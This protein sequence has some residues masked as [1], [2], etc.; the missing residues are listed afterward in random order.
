VLG[1]EYRG[2]GQKASDETTAPVL[3]RG[4]CGRCGA[5]RVD[6]QLGTEPTVQEYVTKLVAVFRELRRVLR[7]DGTFWLVI[8]D[9]YG[10]DGN[11]VGA[12]WRLAFALQD[13]GWVL[14]MDNIWRKPDTMPE[15][16]NNR[17]TKA[18]EYVF[19]FSK[20]PRYYYDAEAVKE[21]SVCGYRDWKSSP[22]SAKGRPGSHSHY[23]GG[24]TTRG[25]GGSTT[26]G[27]GSPRNKRSVW[28]ISHGGGYKGGHFACVDSET[29]ALTRTGWKKHADILQGECIA[30]YNKYRDV[31]VWQPATIHRYEFSGNLVV[32]DKRDTSQHL[33]PNHRC[34]VQSR[35]G[36]VRVKRAAAVSGKDR[37]LMTA[38]FEEQPECTIGRDMAAL[39]GWYTSEGCRHTGRW[40]VQ[41]SQSK[42]ANPEKVEEIRSL[43]YRM[44]A[45]FK[46]VDRS[47]HNNAKERHEMVFHV[48][49]R[50]ANRLL[51]LCPNKQVTD[52]LTRLPKDELTVLLETFISGDGHRRK[53]DYRKCIT[54][55][56]RAHLER[57]QV[58]A[59]KLGYRAH[60]SKRKQDDCHVLYLTKG[61]WLEARGTNG[62]WFGMQTERYDGCVWC[63]NVESGFWLARREG[64][65]FITGNTF[66]KALVEVCVK[67]G[68]SEKGCCPKCG[69]PWARVLGQTRTATR[70]GH[71]TKTHGG[72]AVNGKDAAPRLAGGVT[73]NRDPARHVTTTRTLGWRPSCACYGLPLV[74][75]EPREPKRSPK[76]R[77]DAWVARYSKYQTA[78]ASWEKMWDEVR[79]EYAALLDTVDEG[80]L[81]PCVVLDP[82]MGSGTAALVAL[83]LGRH[84]VGIDVSEAYLRD[85]A[86]ARVRGFLLSRPAYRGLVPME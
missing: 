69:A 74:S 20:G 17:S 80:S 53:N 9:C 28:T 49:G 22:D 24:D 38:E 30:A 60:L 76:E 55:K 31:L 42:L 70:P 35:K 11:L 58:I 79:D 4:V 43:L 44:G 66:P 41:I 65:P 68:T 2:G 52:A 37:F 48:G 1:L 50:V 5:R 82:F 16:T 64:K 10:N 78:L 57:L 56:C 61:R 73:G 32:F 3:Y 33:T 8:G 46:V 81:V 83:R 6:P 21:K 75:N 36:R 71:A 34:L 77:E 63:P 15:S 26:G 86:A 29:E 14:R 59:I 27:D 7:D 72:G 47:L 67:A 85:H 23:K 51:D 18:H 84:A 19:H 54:Q 12:P 13:D 40:P 45:L 62:A 39:V 25:H